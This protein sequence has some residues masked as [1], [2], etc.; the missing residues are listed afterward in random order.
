VQKS[1]ASEASNKFSTSAAATNASRAAADI[2]HHF[3]SHFLA[4]RLTMFASQPVSPLHEDG[5]C[6]VAFASNSIN[7]NDFP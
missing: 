7:R 2:F 4:R 3:S 6:T 5:I 1:A